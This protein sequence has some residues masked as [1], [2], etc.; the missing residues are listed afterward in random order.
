MTRKIALI[1][2][3][4]AAISFADTTAL[5]PN[6][7]PLQITQVADQGSILKVSANSTTGQQSYLVG[8]PVKV[9]LGDGC[10]HFVGEEGS[11]NNGVLQIV[12]MGS[13]DPTETSCQAS[14]PNPVD[15][16][17]NFRVNATSSYTNPI[18]SSVLIGDASYSIS[19]D[20]AEQTVSVGFDSQPRHK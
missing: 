19:I 10:T 12:A 7:K 11:L 8:I 4:F 16:Q 2:S 9:D 13:I 18:Q 20:T 6:L 5:S 17:I 3:I 15:T 1:A 14:L